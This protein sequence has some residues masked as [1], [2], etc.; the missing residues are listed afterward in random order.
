MKGLT[1]TGEVRSPATVKRYLAALSQAF[2]YAVKEL[3]LIN[4]NPVSKVTKPTEPRGRVRWLSK[5]EEINGEM[6]EG[7]RLKLR[8][9]ARMEVSF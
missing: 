5:D 6:V 2:T 3:E 7:E 1:P 9:I 4:E 8:A